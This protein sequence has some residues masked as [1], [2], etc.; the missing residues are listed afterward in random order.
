MRINHPHIAKLYGFFNDAVY[1][2]MVS[3]YMESGNLAK[4]IEEKGGRLP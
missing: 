3:E 1:F 4:T 2:Y